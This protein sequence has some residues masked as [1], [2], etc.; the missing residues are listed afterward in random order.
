[1]RGEEFLENLGSETYNQVSAEAM[2]KK[3]GVGPELFPARWRLI[4]F[5]PFML[6]CTNFD[7]LQ[8]TL[9]ERPLQRSGLFD[10]MMKL[11]TFGH[12]MIFHEVCLRL[13]KY[14]SITEP[15][16]HRFVDVYCGSSLLNDLENWPPNELW[17][18]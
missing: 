2:T 13:V 11:L 12:F 18:S 9:S 10:G 15:S 6:C 3:R 7:V 1:M 17:A 4:V 16:E 5:T 8:Q 14:I